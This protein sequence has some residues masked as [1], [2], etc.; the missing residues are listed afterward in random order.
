MFKFIHLDEAYA[1][2]RLIHGGFKISEFL[3]LNSPPTSP[4]LMHL[5]S[6][7]FPVYARMHVCDESQITNQAPL[8]LFHLYILSERTLQIYLLIVNK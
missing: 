8:E 6:K 3:N 1:R 2:A 5:R 7:Q 4:M